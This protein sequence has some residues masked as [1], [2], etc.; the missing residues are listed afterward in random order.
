MSRL[1]DPQGPAVWRERFQRYSRSGLA[2]ARFC[3]DEG[4]SVASFYYWRKKLGAAAL[5]QQSPAQ[6]KGAS[7]SS[8]VPSELF[9]PVTVVTS[10]NCSV[11][12]E[13]AGGTRIQVPAEQIEALRAAIAEVAQADQTTN[14]GAAS[15]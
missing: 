13:L 2:V 4:V 5:R 10:Q 12:I 7:A 11:T 3:S 6:R 9:K 15:C 1:C 8:S 14:S